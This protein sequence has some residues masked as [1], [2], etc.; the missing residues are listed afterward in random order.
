MIR[1]SRIARTALLNESLGMADLTG[2][3]MCINAMKVLEYI[4]DHDGIA[5]TKTGATAGIESGIETA[6]AT[7]S[8]ASNEMSC[9]R[10]CR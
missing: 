9:R 5:L 3:P 6:V 7:T 8:P 2:S 10:S 4:R 1:R